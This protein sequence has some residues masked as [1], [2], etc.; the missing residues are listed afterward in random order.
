MDECHQIYN[1]VVGPKKSTVV[2]GNMFW[3]D[4]SSLQTSTLVLDRH[5]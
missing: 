3:L 5:R 2:T 4:F 1:T